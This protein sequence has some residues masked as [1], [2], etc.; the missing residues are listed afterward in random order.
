MLVFM[1]IFVRSLEFIP[2]LY[3]TFPLGCVFGWDGVVYSFVLSSR[4]RTL[5]G[6]HVG[7]AR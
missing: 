1:F 2:K 4:V 3:T 6:D 7:G 5:C